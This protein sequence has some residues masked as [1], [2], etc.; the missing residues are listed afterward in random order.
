MRAKT[1]SAKRRKEIAQKGRR[2]A[3]EKLGRPSRPWPAVRILQI[4]N[5]R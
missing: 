3:L 5:G 4:R 2:Y 1:L